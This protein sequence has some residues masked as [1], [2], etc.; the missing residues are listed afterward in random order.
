MAIIVLFLC[1]VYT[2]FILS[3]LAAKA[4][5]IKGD[6]YYYRAVIISLL[7]DRDLLLEDDVSNPLNGQLAV[8]KHG[9]VPK[10]PIIMSLVSLPF[11]LLFRDLGLLLFNII[12]SMTLVL[13]MFNLNSLFFRRPIAFIAAALYATGTLFLNYTYNYSPDVFAAV[14][15]LGGLC[16]VL[17]ERFY[18]GAFLLGLSVFAKLP[19]A[20]LAGII[21]VYAAFAI[22]RPLRANT[23]SPPGSLRGRVAVIVGIMAVFAVALVPLAYTNDF[24]F[25]SPFVTGYQRTALEGGTPGQVLSIDH[26]HKFNQPLV[27]GLSRLLFD[28]YRGLIPTNPVVILAF[29]GVIWIKRIGHPAQ[30]ALIVTLCLTQLIFFARYD[31]WNASHFSNRFLMPFVALSSVFAGN[32]LTYLNGKVPVLKAEFV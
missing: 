17:R 7:E 21:L 16:F 22:W 11:Y 14:L 27:Q 15:L 9:L 13:L 12:T 10:H 24:L 3:S 28:R 5:F 1:F 4:T 8:G 25:G 6:C 30:A 19:N 20:L 2:P 32:F 23:S 18:A 26:T 31:E 29:L